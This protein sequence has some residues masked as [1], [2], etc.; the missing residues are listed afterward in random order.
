M[1]LNGLKELFDNPNVQTY[2]AR[3]VRTIRD[4]KDPTLKQ[5][6]MGVVGV[7]RDPH[8]PI[9]DWERLD[10]DIIVIPRQ[11]YKNNDGLDNMRID[12]AMQTLSNDER[13]TTK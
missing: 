3:M 10:C 1:D 4:T 2:Q 8:E 5:I 13:W 6:T 11:A 7:S 9:H 12:Q